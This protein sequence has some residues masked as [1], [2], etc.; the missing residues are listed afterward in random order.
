MPVYLVAGARQYAFP[1]SNSNLV[2]LMPSK[3]HHID[4]GSDS[5]LSWK[6]TSTR[7]LFPFCTAVVGLI[8]ST[9]KCYGW[10]RN[11]GES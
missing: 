7:V 1:A 10:F 5:K 8:P 4:S 2:E 3:L 9:V 6:I 11:L